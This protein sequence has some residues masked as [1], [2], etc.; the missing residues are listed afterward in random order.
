M[1]KDSQEEWTGG[2]RTQ[3]HPSAT[4]STKNSA[5]TDPGANP[6]F[7]DDR[8]ATNRLSHGTAKPNDNYNCTVCTTCFNNQFYILHKYGIYVF[9]FF[10]ILRINSDYFPK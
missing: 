5:W 1:I 10:T 7:C 8:Q 4:L 6:G 2:G 9:F 3:N